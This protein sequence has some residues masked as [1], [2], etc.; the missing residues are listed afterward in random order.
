MKIFLRI[1]GIIVFVSVISFSIIS[2]NFFK[3]KD[4]S[5]CGGTGQACSYPWITATCSNCYESWPECWVCS[6]TGKVPDW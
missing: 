6:G 3:E 1:L 4:C 2:C 5:H